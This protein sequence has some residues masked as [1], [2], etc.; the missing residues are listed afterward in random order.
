MAFLAPIALAAFPGFTTA[1]AASTTLGSIGA[2][3]SALGAIGSGIATGNA[4]AYSAEVA[5][6]NAQIERENAARASAAGET[7]AQQK[8]LQG[9]EQLGQIKAAQGASNID[10]NTGSALNVQAGQRQLNQLDAETVLSNAELTGYGY[11]QQAASNDAQAVLDERE[12]EEAPIAGAFGAAG[13][14]LSNAAGISNKWLTATGA[15]GASTPGYA[16][17]PGIGMA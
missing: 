10:V 15:S 5:K 6:Q 1:A 17:G 4:A 7:A 13:S 9:A 14:F 12:A 16:G 8:S 3:V 2:G 11:R